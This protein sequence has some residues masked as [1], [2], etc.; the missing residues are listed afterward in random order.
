MSTLHLDAATLE[1]VKD[2][3]TT[4]ADPRGT[5]PDWSLTAADA[6]SAGAWVP[7]SWSGDWSET[8]GR[9][10]ALSPQIGAAGALVLAE[11]NTYKLWI[12]WTANGDTPVREVGYIVAS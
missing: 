7:G 2:T 11:G 12:R 3:V 6:T 10:T 1:T 5:P 9:A 4:S 8:S